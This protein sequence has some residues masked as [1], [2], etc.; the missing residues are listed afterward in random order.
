LPGDRISCV[1][2]VAD[3]LDNVAGCW[4]AGFAPTG[5]KDPYALRRHVLAVL[6]ILVD[7]GARVDL[8]AALAEAMG[9]VAV[10]KEGKEVSGVLDEIHDFVRTRMAGHFTENLDCNPAAVRAVLPVRWRDPLDA[11]AWTRALAGFRDQEDFQLLATGFKRCRN[12]L[13][14]NVLE[15]RELDNCL[16]R[17]LAGGQGA[18]GED[19]DGL[20]EPAERELRDQVTAAAPRLVQAEADRDYS[21]VFAVFSGLG[22]AIDAFFETVRVN[23]E[24]DALRRVRHGF[25]R[26]IHGLFARFADFSQVAPLDQG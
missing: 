17:W 16:E 6:R 9:P 24:N 25:L 26:E 7:L 22:P 5:A 1:L 10:F 12:I 20:T 11:L 23:V 2:S 13:K 15:V 18:A 19:F 21:Q 3:R 4:L 14:G 8:E